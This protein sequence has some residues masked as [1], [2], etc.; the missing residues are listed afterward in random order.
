MS[1]DILELFNKV[2]AEGAKRGNRGEKATQL[3]QFIE[4]TIKTIRKP[5]IK[6][7]TLRGMCKL[8][9]PDLKIEHSYF[10]SLV[11][12]TYVVKNNDDGDLVVMTKEKK[13]LKP[14]RTKKSSTTPPGE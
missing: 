7:S 13:E 6:V 10:T 12:A 11:K 2:E 8:K 4:E 3:R 9:F 1:D 14:A 5:E